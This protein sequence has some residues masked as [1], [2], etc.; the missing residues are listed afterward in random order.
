MSRLPTSGFRCEPDPEN[1][2]WLTW[3][4]LDP[5]RFNGAAMGKLIVRRESENASR[6]RMVPDYR[7]ANIPGSLHG[8]VTLALIDIALFASLYVLRQGD[9][10]GAVTLE[11]NTQFIGSGELEEP[12]DAITEILRETRRL[13]FMRGTVEQNGNLI[14]AYS[15]MIRKPSA[16]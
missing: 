3:D 2:G 12:L 5:A 6:V 16:T 8:G 15:G 7:H 1:P 4:A 13:A 10:V 14:A 11:M 9:S